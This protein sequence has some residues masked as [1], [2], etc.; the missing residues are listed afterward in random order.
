MNT[1]DQYPFSRRHFVG[2]GGLGLAAAAAAPAFAQDSAQGP[3]AAGRQEDA[4]SNPTDKYP[5]PPFRGSR[6]PGQDWQAEWI[7]GPIMAKRAIGG[8]AGSL[9]ARRW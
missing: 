9:A 3:A 4:L 7:R 5:K 2:A 8:M 6:S 1:S